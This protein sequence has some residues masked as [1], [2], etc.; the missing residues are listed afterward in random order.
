ML[1]VAIDRGGRRYELELA[2]PGMKTGPRRVP[3]RPDPS[4]VGAGNWGE[5]ERRASRLDSVRV[6]IAHT[7]MAA[8]GESHRRRSYGLVGATTPSVRRIATKSQTLV[9]NTQAT[10]ARKTTVPGNWTSEIQRRALS[11]RS[12]G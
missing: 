8:G 1:A 4:G 3:T 11:C 6:A 10:N 7:T 12:S 5:T 9:A 2:A